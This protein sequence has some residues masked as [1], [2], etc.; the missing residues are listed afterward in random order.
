MGHTARIAF[1]LPERDAK[2]RDRGLTNALDAG[3]GLAAI[4][5]A[6]SV[7]GAYTDVVKLGWGTAHVTP[8]LED[9][10]AL[11]RSHDVRSSPGGLLF[12]LSYW[13]GKMADYEAFVRDAGFALVEVS[14][15]SLPIAEADKCREVARLAD[16][17]FTVLSEVG[18]KD[19]DFEMA[20]E[21]W[22]AAIK[23]DID[24]GAWK[25]IVE[26]RAD[27]SAGIYG[28]D[29]KVRG[30][31]IDAILQS[32]VDPER[33]IFEAPFK[34]QMIYF[35]T[36]LGPNVNLANV[37]LHEVINLETLRLGLRGHTVEHFHA[38]G[39]HNAHAP[40]EKV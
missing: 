10:L 29:G 12:E 6:L 24:A 25:V 19:A 28:A 14:N 18:S 11:Y 22:V 27:A 39:H 1:D 31:A 15:G 3:L 33:L 20:P 26:G 21:A 8:N 5:D 4:A 34:P 7:C 37:P 35:V 23:A 36:R 38:P 9:K 16:A 13:Q 32:G 2:P 30:D 17:G 40:T